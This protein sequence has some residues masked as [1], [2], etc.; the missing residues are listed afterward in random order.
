MNW[1]R[2]R[3]SPGLAL[4]LIAPLLGELVSGHQPPLEFFNPLTFV[5]MALPYGFGALICRELVV[6]W[7]KGKLSLLLMSIAY[8]LYEEAVVIKSVFN[9]NW[10][11]LGAIGPYNYWGGINWTYS[12][13]LIH[14]HITVSI[15]GSVLIAEAIYHERAHERWLTD[16]QLALT[17]LGLALWIPFGF[18]V[19]PEIPDVPLYVLAV[20]CM[21]AL[22]F[23][24]GKIPAH[25]WKRVNWAVKNPWYFMA[26]GFIDTAII[27]LGASYEGPKPPL[28]VMFAALVLVDIVSFWLLARWSAHGRWGRT[29]KVALVFGIL[30]FF[31]IAAGLQ[32]TEGFRGHSIVSV[33]SLWVL[34]RFYWR[35]A[36]EERGALAGRE[37]A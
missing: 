33:I 23:A 24:A 34:L 7:G 14:F 2:K 1:L 10:S 12:L 3:I 27:L 5:L 6:R 17:G 28:Y 15:I 30:L 4:L 36:K 32:D 8:G 9:P 22:V 19:M 18:I 29:H 16:W 20:V 31:I 21:A 35:V 26:L 37:R 25:P 11:E 13:M